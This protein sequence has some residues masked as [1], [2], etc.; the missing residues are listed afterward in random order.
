M[1]QSLRRLS[2]QEMW[3]FLKISHGMAWLMNLQRTSRKVSI[4]DEE[5]EFGDQQDYEE[6]N[7]DSYRQR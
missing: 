3:S 2:F 7:I 4:I 6:S 5:D 1:I